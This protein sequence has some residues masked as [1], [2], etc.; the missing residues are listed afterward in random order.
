MEKVQITIAD[1]ARLSNVSKTTVSRII[2]G[3]YGKVNKETKERVLKI[4]EELDYQPNTLA[5]GLKQKTTNVIGIV[6]SKLHPFWSA[7]LEGVEDAC[8]SRGYSLMISNTGDDPEIEVQQIKSFI[9]RKVDGVI[10]SPTIHNKE[11]YEE[12]IKRSYPI[13]AISRKTPNLSLNTVAMDDI[14]GAWLATEHLLSL[15]KERIMLVVYPPN[16]ISPRYERV[17]GF[18]MTLKAHGN[19]LG[20]VEIVEEKPGRAK[21]KIIEVLKEKKVDA[22]ISTN[23]NLNLEIMKAIKESGLKVP[24]EIAIV[25]YDDSDWAELVEPPLT[26]VY[27]PAYE[28][29]EKAAKR[30]I[31]LIKSSENSE[32]ETTMF[33]PKLIIRKSCGEKE[34]REYDHK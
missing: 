31:E 11:F 24:Q 28:M 17:A 3:N 12:L 34:S 27:Q 5:Q 30:L 22:I 20:W 29:G 23:N 26:T 32:S 4:I 7:V 8:R 9:Q 21:Q 33:D 1:I 15:G 10:V 14:K 19:N 6:L 25:G 18:E 16:E 2:N 13:V